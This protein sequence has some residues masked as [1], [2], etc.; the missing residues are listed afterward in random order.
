MIVLGAARGLAV[1]RDLA[2]RQKTRRLRIERLERRGV[3][4]ATVLCREVPALAS[5]LVATAALVVALGGVAYGTIPDSNG[6]I[7]GCVL[8]SGQLR[9]IDTGAGQTCGTNETPLNW[10]QSGRSGTPV[11]AAAYADSYASGG[12]TSDV[13]Q[14]PIGYF[15]TGGGFTYQAFP[16]KV[17]ESTPVV[18][19]TNHIR[20]ADAWRVTMENSSVGA[21]FTT[22]AICLP[23]GS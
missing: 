6:A 22:Y 7:H 8:P 12:Q 11:I 2:S 20:S 23:Q 5:L 9:V 14:C 3:E 17:D 21:H 19:V 10:N 1:A 4:D 13:A 15:V 16:L 18:T